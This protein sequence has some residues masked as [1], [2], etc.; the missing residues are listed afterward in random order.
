MSKSKILYNGDNNLKDQFNHELIH[1]LE[2]SAKRGISAY[3]SRDN[4][5][6]KMNELGKLSKILTSHN[7]L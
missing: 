6:K 4:S 5:L 1:K 7:K 2:T 3:S